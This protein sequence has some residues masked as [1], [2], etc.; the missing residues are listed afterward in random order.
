MY[1]C[2]GFTTTLMCDKVRRTL[3]SVAYHPIEQDG[4]TA[5]DF[6]YEALA[7]GNVLPTMPL[8]LRGG[9]CMP[10]ALEATYQRTCREQRIA[11]E[12]V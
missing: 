3:Y 5:L 10:V 11:V 1:S 4:A 6:W 12:P 2:N 9:P 8:W 7:L